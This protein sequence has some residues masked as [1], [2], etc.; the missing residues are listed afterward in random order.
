MNSP[1]PHARTLDSMEKTE[2][3]RRLRHVVEQARRDATARRQ[4]ATAAEQAG[5][6][7]LSD[8]AAPLFRSVVSALKTEGYSF[9]VSTPPGAVQLS[10]ETSTDD[11]IELVLDT[12]RDPPALM[13]RIRRVW[14]S[15]VIAT[16]CVVKEEPGLDT[17]SEE[18]V[19]DF[20][21]RELTPFVER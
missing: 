13:G 19:L 12:T 21:L 11:V 8:I 15:R 5:T 16:E 10:S 9:R 14:G 7:V 18:E 20:L 4:R 3:Y 1:P 2:I 17:V 6:T